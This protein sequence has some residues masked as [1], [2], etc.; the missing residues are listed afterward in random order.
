MNGHTVRHPGSAVLLLWACMSF[1][2]SN[3]VRGQIYLPTGQAIG[4]VVELRLESDDLRR[5]MEIYYSDSQGRFFIPGIS[6]RSYFT[7]TVP[8]DGKTYDT[9]VI[10]FSPGVQPS[11]PIH[12]KPLEGFKI[13]AKSATIS[14]EE[15]REPLP[16]AKALH[17][18][19]MAL[20]KDKKLNAA[21]EKLR[22]AIEADPRYSA[23][24]N[25]LGVVLIAQRRYADAE[26]TLRKGLAMNPDSFHALYNLGVALNY[27]GR[28]QD[29]TVPLRAALKKEPQWVNA[30]AQL[31]IALL[32]TDH[33]EAARPCLER[34]LQAEGKDKT[35]AYLY[36]GKLHAQQ[37]TFADAVYAWDQ[38]LALDSSSANS[39][40]I[41]NLLEQIRPR[42]VGKTTEIKATGTCE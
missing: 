25:D 29:A 32:E 15:L 33:L 18:D 36:L 28:H 3:S 39:A 34:G 2:Q 1:A 11:L 16:K 30:E 17:D 26:S 22:K 37:G 24:Y 14:T 13:V 27:Q 7:I 12:L 4:T 42:A 23:P 9:T 8:G 38:Y 31:G 40:N 20:V 41:R 6:A 10:H 35:F 21:Q 5:Q 19:A